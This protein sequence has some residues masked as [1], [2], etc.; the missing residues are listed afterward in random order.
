[1]SDDRSL[2]PDE[3][4]ER[5]LARRAPHGPDT[6]LL[7]DV[8]AGVRS[9]PQGGRWGAGAG[10][11]VRGTRRRTVW[12]ALAA[13]LATIIVAGL[14]GT[15]GSPPN[16]PGITEVPTPSPVSSSRSTPSPSPIP[17]ATDTIQATAIPVGSQT[18]DRQTYQGLGSGWAAYLTTVEP[19]PSPGGYDVWVATTG[20]PHPSAVARLVGTGINSATILH[21]P[22]GSAAFLVS[23]GHV[24]GGGSAPWC[25]DLYLVAMDGSSVMRLTHDRARTD[26]VGAA[27]SPDGRTAYVTSEPPDSPTPWSFGIVDASG[28][29][30][31]SVTDLCHAPGVVAPAWSDDGRFVAFVCSG[32]IIVI[33]PS[34]SGERVA[35]DDHLSDPAAIGWTPDLKIQILTFDQPPKPGPTV[36]IVDPATGTIAI[37]AQPG[38]AK[39]EWVAPGIADAFSPDGRYVALAASDDALWVLDLQTDRLRLAAGADTHAGL[40]GSTWTI[41]GSALAYVDGSDLTGLRLRRQAIGS[42]TESVLGFLPYDFNG[43]SLIASGTP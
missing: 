34:R 24:T 41:D 26:I 10:S 17:C 30:E 27:L 13:A 5:A 38:D 33:D 37:E 14:I 4:I 7:A 36:S 8:M 42:G 19:G 25:T 31:M 32:Q 28:S 6:V 16:L 15:L 22:A 9:A 35:I 21:A 40:F 18:D 20:R 29:P 39:T 11:T 3:T 1:M 2:P 43:G 23:I 12:I